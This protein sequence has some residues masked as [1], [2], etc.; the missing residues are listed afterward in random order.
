MNELLCKIADKYNLGNVLAKPTR[1][2]GGLLHISYKLV[3]DKGTYI[4]KLFGKTEDEKAARE[5]FSKTDDLEKLLESAKV[6]AVYALRFNGMGVQILDGQVFY[7]FPWYEG[8]AI[9]GID[10][11]KCQV[12][13][14]AKVTAK[15]NNIKMFEVDSQ[16]KALNID[17]DTLLKKA[18]SAK[19]TIYPMLKDNIAML[20]DLADK[21]NIY[22]PKLP[23]VRALCHNDMDCKNVLWK[24]NRYKLIDLECIGYHSPYL[25]AFK[26]ALCW[27]GY[28]QYNIDFDKYKLFLK[29]Y[30]RHCHLDKNIDFNILYYGCAL[31]LEWLE[32]SIK[33]ALKIVGESAEEQELGISQTE[34][35]INQIKHYY[36]HKDE[37]VNV[38]R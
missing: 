36:E 16:Y 35:T 9:K 12:K 7:I 5:K 25:E 8:A 20:K 2:Y 38:L 30:F 17:W 28:E 23:K 15:I 24:G 11:T 33:R 21:A 27:T 29:T 14:M 26:N 34:L 13:K 1:V 37:I 10:S 31:G 32:F 22:G 3:T 19:S 4:V 18:K 6:K